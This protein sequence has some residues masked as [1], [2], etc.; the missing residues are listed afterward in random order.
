MVKRIANA[1]KIL[2]EAH[3]ILRQHQ[4]NKEKCSKKLNIVHIRELLTQRGVDKREIKGNKADL[5]K[6]YW[7]VHVDVEFQ[8]HV[9]MKVGRYFPILG[10]PQLFFGEVKEI[11]D[12]FYS[13]LYNDGDTEDMDIEQL[14]YAH[15]LFIAKSY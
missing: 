3:H 9:G 12:D 14:E 7:K 13:I 10:K 5:I 4:S 2:A 8:P 1:K 11:S 6:K 15:G